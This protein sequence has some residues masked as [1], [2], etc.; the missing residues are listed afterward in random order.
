M[1]TYCPHCGQMHPD[2]FNFCPI[3]GKEIVV[4]LSKPSETSE[5]QHDVHPSS[6]ERRLHKVYDDSSDCFSIKLLETEIKMIR[7]PGD[8]DKGI[9][10]FYISET[11]ITMDQMRDVILDFSP[12]FSLKNSLIQIIKFF[13]KWNSNQLSISLP[14]IFQM[15]HIAN[16]HHNLI[17]WTRI[18]NK[19]LAQLES[20]NWEKAKIILNSGVF[21]LCY[22]LVCYT[23]PK[24]G[25]IL[26]SIN[27]VNNGINIVPEREDSSIVAHMAYFHIVCSEKSANDFIKKL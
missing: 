14:S 25:F 21:I 26:Y 15:R 3:F 12:W 18:S 8:L 19:G 23:L 24:L 6:T 17:K 27:K 10:P 1:P 22:P 5:L 11:P 4:H 9:E 16:N 7:I 20:V 2:D 13:S